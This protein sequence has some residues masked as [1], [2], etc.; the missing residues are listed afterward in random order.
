MNKRQKKKEQSKIKRSQAESVIDDVPNPIP[1][2]PEPDIDVEVDWGAESQKN[3]SDGFDFDWD[4]PTIADDVDLL[5]GDGS[6][7]VGNAEKEQ[8]IA[9]TSNY[10]DTFPKTE[11]KEKPLIDKTIFP[12]FE[13]D[14]FNENGGMI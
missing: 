12:D 14:I 1:S 8:N 9:P 11:T 2:V 5:A 7:F 3:E 6:A 13:N 4:D 10:T